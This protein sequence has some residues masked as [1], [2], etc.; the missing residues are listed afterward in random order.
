MGVVVGGVGVGGG[1]VGV[2]LFLGCTIWMCISVLLFDGEMGAAHCL[3][4]AT[5]TNSNN[6][7]D[8]NNIKDK[9]IGG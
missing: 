8:N 7:N 2:M 9:H 5:H 3:G 6:N 1:G 4:R